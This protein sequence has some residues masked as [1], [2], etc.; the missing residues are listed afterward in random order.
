MIN[1][2]KQYIENVFVIVDS[3]VHNSN[4]FIKVSKQQWRILEHFSN[5][6]IEIC[7]LGWSGNKVGWKEVEV[8][9]EKSNKGM[10]AYDQEKLNNL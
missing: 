8:Y 5:G 6:G 4:H 2:Y 3:D 7:L 1:K 10:E 9:Q